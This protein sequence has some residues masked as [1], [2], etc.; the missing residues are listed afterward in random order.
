MDFGRKLKY[1]RTRKNISQKEL[2][3]L[4][5]VG[6]TTISNYETGRNEPSHEKLKILASYFD[7]SIDYLLGKSDNDNISHTDESIEDDDIFEIKFGNVH[8][9]VDRKTMFEYFFKWLLN[10]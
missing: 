7:T 9:R 6:V 1:L 2:A 4:L 5:N 3:K 10:S 8:K